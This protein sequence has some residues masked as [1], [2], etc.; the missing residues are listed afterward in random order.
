[1]TEHGQGRGC[2]ARPG[3]H[4]DDVEDLAEVIE[5]ALCTNQRRSE[6]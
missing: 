1:M 2:P 4:L 3:P 5:R 6:M